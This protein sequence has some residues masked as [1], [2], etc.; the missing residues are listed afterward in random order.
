MSDFWLQPSKNI[1]K[2]NV[3]Q[4]GG[5]WGTPEDPI[6]APRGGR[7]NRD[8]GHG[9]P[10]GQDSNA[11]PPRYRNHIGSKL[12]LFATVMHDVVFTIMQPCQK[13][14][15][16]RTTNAQT[17]CHKTTPTEAQCHWMIMNRRTNAARRTRKSAN[18]MNTQAAL[19]DMIH[20]LKFL[21]HQPHQ[22]QVETSHCR[23]DC[24]ENP[25]YVAGMR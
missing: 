9:R 18:W 6:G 23:S 22:P 20:V 16:R 7:G 5:P 3:F 11:P 17:P 8:P 19:R 4:R 25:W 15:P 2:I 10:T 13:E 1:W 12:T 14:A 21:Q 24:Q